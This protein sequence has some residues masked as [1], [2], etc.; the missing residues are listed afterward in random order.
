MSHSPLLDLE[1]SRRKLLD[2][3]AK[4]GVGGVL[5]STLS[6]LPFSRKAVAEGVGSA[7][8]SN[9]TVKHS[10]CL[11]NCGSRCALKVSVDDDRIVRVE[12]EDVADDSEFG[13]HQI[14]F[15]LACV[16]APTVSVCITRIG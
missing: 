4:I 7:A 12:P 10:A 3:S 9:I 11:V 8:A 14:R 2:Y 16:A 15:A 1:L 5:A 13:K 6:S